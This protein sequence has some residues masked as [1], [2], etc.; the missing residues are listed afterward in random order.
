[1]PEIMSH[2]NYSSNTSESDL[3][4]ISFSLIDSNE[5]QEISYEEVEEL[6]N[7]LI[8]ET[9]R[10]RE[11][12]KNTQTVVTTSGSLCSLSLSTTT[13]A[14]TSSSSPPP[15]S[16]FSPQKQLPLS[17]SQLTSYSETNRKCLATTK[18]DRRMAKQM[19]ER[20]R[21]D[22]INALLDN[23][24]TLILKLLHKNPRHHRKLE[25][26]DI[27]ELVVSFLKKE[28]H[29]NR[30]RTTS[31]N[32]QQQHQDNCRSIYSLQNLNYSSGIESSLASIVYPDNHNNYYQHRLIPS[33]PQSNH[34]L[35]NNYYFMKNHDNGP[36]KINNYPISNHIEQN[37]KSVYPTISYQPS[38][39][40]QHQSIPS[41]HYS[42]S[43]SYQP[44]VFTSTDDMNKEN[45]LITGVGNL[46]NHTNT[47]ITKDLHYYPTCNYDDYT[48]EQ[49][50]VRQPLNILNKAN[51]FI[52]QN[53]CYYSD[54]KIINQTCHHQIQPNTHSKI[55]P[56]ILNSHLNYKLLPIKD[57]NYS[58]SHP[59]NN[60]GVGNQSFRSVTNHEK[61]NSNDNNSSDFTFGNERL[62]SKETTSLERLWR[63]Y[64]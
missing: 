58:K 26:A 42:Q 5:E 37:T 59:Y 23:L 63:P 36:S 45:Q 14:I 31:S 60:Y 62:C 47:P 50:A 17:S 61:N 22:R 25:K 54:S 56:D 3:N 13:M 38:Y 4:E 55:Y 30:F 43:T 28:L 64:V 35:T 19:T 27:L 46:Q 11:L 49:D 10:R 21:R 34:Q 41:S 52:G 24:R 48:F 40:H 15:M 12:L 44:I 57:E 51:S 29:Q 16:S 7:E 6:K 39:K 20:K 9:E 18:H 8:F 1:M 53:N 2:I 32:S 33:I